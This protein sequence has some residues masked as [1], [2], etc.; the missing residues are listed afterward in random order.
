MD[1]ADLEQILSNDPVFA[2][3]PPEE[4]TRVCSSFVDVALTTGQTVFCAGD[5]GDA[6]F[7][8][9]SGR[10]R[11]V[12]PL[13]D[14]SEIN[15]AVVEKG[16]YFGEQ[17]LLTGA[18]RS[19]TVRAVDELHL[20]R[21]DREV[22][23]ALVKRVPGLE[24]KLTDLARQQA[25]LGFLRRIGKIVKLGAEK[26]K[27]LSAAVE[28]L[29]V[30]A[31]TTIMRQGD[32]PDRLY[33]VK[34]GRVEVLQTEG[35]REYVLGEV[36]IGG[37][38]GELG[39]L[40]GSPRQA[41]VVARTRSEL[42]TLEGERFLKLLAPGPEARVKLLE[43]LSAFMLARPP[44][45]TEAEAEAPEAQAPGVSAR[46][47][48]FPVHPVSAPEGTGKACLSMVLARLGIEDPEAIPEIADGRVD[49]RSLWQLAEAAEAIGLSARGCQLTFA[50]LTGVA[51]PIIVPFR[52]KGYVVVYQVS[53]EEVILG[54]PASG[55]RRLHREEFQRG[56]SGRSLVV[57]VRARLNRESDG[58]GMLAPL[59]KPYWRLLANI[60]V[61]AVILNA[62][63]MSTPFLTQF[64]LDRVIVHQSHT[65]LRTMTSAVVL[66]AIFTL[67][68]RATQK[69]WSLWLAT[70]V[71]FSL[72]DQFY[73]HSL[74]LPVSYYTT[75]KIGDITG[76]FQQNERVQHFLTNEALKALL[77]VVL[78]LMYAVTMVTL[79]FKLGLMVVLYIPVY[80]ALT[81]SVAPWLVALANK[82]F[83]AS[84]EA[85]SALIESIT[86]IG[87]VKG[88]ALEEPVQRRW[89]GHFTEYIRHQ[90]AGFRLG[91]MV[92]SFTSFLTDVA[93]TGIMFWGAYQVLDGRMSIG[94][95]MAFYTL[96]R[97]VMEP[98]QKL[99]G[100]YGQYQQA[101]MSLDRVNEVLDSRP[102]EEE[103]TRRYRYRMPPIRGHVQF[104]R[105]KFSYVPAE[106]R[107]VLR[108]IDLEIKPG[109]MVAVVGR[110]GAGK[111]TL[112]HLLL[113]LV[114]PTQGR[115]LIDGVDLEGVDGAS[116]RRQI[117]VIL[118]DSFLFS[119]TIRE[120]I[121]PMQQDAVLEH[122][123]AAASLA[124]AHEFVSRLP[125]GYDTVVGERGAW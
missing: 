19:A 39:I 8:V 116:L 45:Q 11:I 65:L 97:Q 92:S 106:G 29:V 87:T 42:L 54:D 3:L 121:A 66:I 103:E 83:Y 122:I 7:V 32:S 18:R 58:M 81:F 5:D 59:V 120:N 60:V 114:R 6:F 73:R 10:A 20:F 113:R 101:L 61:A 119:G 41:T 23:L 40:T 16:G 111:S 51:L 62:F 36:P 25:L 34:G 90:F 107:M 125:L 49:E 102:E 48:T 9:S 93:T 2:V 44:A 24:Q 79:N 12:S 30:P 89:E 26:L 76:R 27:Q 117:G 82:S 74:D 67:L 1:T 124:G 28:P 77:D 118:Q 64:I 22:F 55:L 86:G 13:P 56:W 68:L 72:V 98:V 43:G 47:Y 91:L 53:P 14:G 37:F 69:Y 33:I 109:E 78:V 15:L 123:Q 17:S 35:D 75:N 71:N 57:A 99:V 4:L 80:I 104:E 31:G 70:R 88:L 21:L 112:A 110:S 108:G 84:V 52:G 46:G 115:V 105:L 85:E 95:L 50:Q 63:G 38:I 96:M 94:A 100:T